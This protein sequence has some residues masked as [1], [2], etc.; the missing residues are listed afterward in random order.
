MAQFGKPGMDMKR[1]EASV[2]AD[3]EFLRPLRGEWRPQRKMGQSRAANP[4]CDSSVGCGMCRACTA[5]IRAIAARRRAPSRRDCFTAR[6][7]ARGNPDDRMSLGRIRSS[8]RRAQRGCSGPTGSG[9]RRTGSR[10]GRRGGPHVR[11]F[12]A[13][14]NICRNSGW[15]SLRRRRSRGGADLAMGAPRTRIAL[16]RLPSGAPSEM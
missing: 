6:M 11:P 4:P 8:C 16:D 2:P 9:C 5:R 3:G 1:W 15:S 13:L 12:A 14:G 10:P 7:D